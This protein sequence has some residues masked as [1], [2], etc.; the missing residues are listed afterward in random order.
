MTINKWRRRW[1]RKEKMNM[2]NG[3]QEG[4]EEDGDIWD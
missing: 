1:N 4:E 2:W 3:V